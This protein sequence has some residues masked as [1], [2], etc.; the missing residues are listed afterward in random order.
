MPGGTKASPHAF[1][2]P[3]TATRS[4][5][6]TCRLRV[7]EALVTASHLSAAAALPTRKLQFISRVSAI[8]HAPIRQKHNY[9]G[10]CS[11]TTVM[12]VVCHAML[13]RYARS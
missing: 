8:L 5:V 4:A 10:L 2:T 6:S 9:A 7:A 13:C 12:C 3:F 1:H 11:K